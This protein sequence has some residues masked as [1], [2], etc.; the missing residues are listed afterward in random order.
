M[1]GGSLGSSEREF[2]L[3]SEASVLTLLQLVR[4][5]ALDAASKDDI[6]DLVFTYRNNPAAETASQLATFL[7]PLNVTLA[8]SATPANKAAVPV[9]VTSAAAAVGEQSPAIPPTQATT[10]GSRRAQ[11]AFASAAKQPTTS[12]INK[13]PITIATEPE[14]TPESVVETETPAPVAEPVPTPP[15]APAP[16]P[17]PVP[18]VAAAPAP[19]AEV[20]PEPVSEPAIQAA[21]PSSDAL[22][23]IKEIKHLVNEQVGNP[24]NLIDATNEVGREYMTALLEAMKT[25]NGGGDSAAA[26]SRLEAAFSAVQTTLSNNPI[27]AP[28]PPA[29]VSTPAT[30]P[31]PAAQTEAPVAETVPKPPTPQPEPAAKANPTSNPVPESTPVSE[32]ATAPTPAAEPAAATPLTSVAAGE[33]TS[34]SAQAAEATKPVEP[35]VP[36]DP[37]QTELV[38]QGLSQ[39]LS[40]WN[41]FKGGG[42]LGGRAK[43][44]DH[45]LYKELQNTPMNLIIAGRFEGATPEVKQSLHDYMNGWRFEQGITHDLKE[46]FEHYLRRVVKT[47][48]DKQPKTE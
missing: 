37:L 34:V 14:P 44:V 12:P 46:T 21:T 43:G 8:G 35:E 16:E 26:M 22:T 18:E 5:S 9:K 38:T 47:I 23:R 29:E 3:N 11:P 24:V 4:H 31:E 39:L 6:R 13:V 42:I 25:A 1:N 17:T 15:P 30:T 27:A 45:P 20:T 40:E 10:L 41:L 32:V 33:S 7:V 19:A 2:D 36:S 48:I 28:T